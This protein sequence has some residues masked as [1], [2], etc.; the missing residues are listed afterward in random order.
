MG[1]SMKAS[2]EGIAEG[3]EGSQPW[4]KLIL[5][6]RQLNGFASGRGN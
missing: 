1:P 6:S 2:L 4:T 3:S 5:S